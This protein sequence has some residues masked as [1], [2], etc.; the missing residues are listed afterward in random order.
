MAATTATLGKA[1]PP[2]V[3]RTPRSDR[4]SSSAP[5]GPRYPSAA[6]TVVSRVKSSAFGTSEAIAARR[7]SR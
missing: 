5:V 1:S 3:L 6:G 7:G 4:G 2:I